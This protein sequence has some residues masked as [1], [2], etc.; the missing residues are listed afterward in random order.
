MWRNGRQ[1]DRG[2]AADGLLALVCAI[3]MLIKQRPLKDGD[4]MQIVD[5]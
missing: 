5:A 1:I 2:V 4:V 3:D